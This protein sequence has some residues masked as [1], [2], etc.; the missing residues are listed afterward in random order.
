MTHV[1]PYSS[2][3]SVDRMFRHYLAGSKTLD[4]HLEEHSEGL[5]LWIHGH[6]HNGVGMLE[7]NL[8]PILNSGSI[9]LGRFSVVQLRKK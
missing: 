4:R 6:T 3:T 1:G 2:G 5:L 8:K 9:S 7:S